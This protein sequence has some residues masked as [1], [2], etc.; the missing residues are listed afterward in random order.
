MT[1]CIQCFLLHRN[2][3]CSESHLLDLNNEEYFRLLL[4]SLDAHPLI[5]SGVKNFWIRSENG[6]L[7]KISQKVDES[8][9]CL[10]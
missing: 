1:L 5:A 4:M 3:L 8:I 7:E 10:T 2:E 9:N 6:P